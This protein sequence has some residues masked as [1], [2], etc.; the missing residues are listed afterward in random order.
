[1]PTSDVAFDP[2][3]GGGG[4]GSG[5]G[6]GVGSGGGGGVGSGGGSG[7]TRD[8]ASAARMQKCDDHG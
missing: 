1:M 6:G 7:A 8:V 2:R 5:G 4:V 3:F